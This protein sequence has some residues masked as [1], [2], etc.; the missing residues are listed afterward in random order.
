[1]KGA[2]SA[3]PEPRAALD[4]PAGKVKRSAP[5]SPRA[6]SDQL[7]LG[8][9]GF[10]V[11]FGLWYALVHFDVWRFGKLPSPIGVIAEWI[12]PSPKYGT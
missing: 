10:V 11:F 12:S 1:M 5:R 3:I 2:S 8:V 4:A 7:R 9:L 6:A